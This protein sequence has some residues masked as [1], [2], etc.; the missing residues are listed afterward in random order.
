MNKTRIYVPI[1]RANDGRAYLDINCADT[2]LASARQKAY[3]ADM[4]AGG[5]GYDADFIIRIQEFLLLWGTP[6]A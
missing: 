3:N 6:N 1:R 4:L 5:H 2:S